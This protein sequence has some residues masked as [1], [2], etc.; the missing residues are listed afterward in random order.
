MKRIYTL[1]TIIAICCC[2]LKSFAQ[3]YSSGIGLFAGY[4]D[5]GYAT[6]L[7][8]NHYPE[9]DRYIQAG[10]YVSFNENEVR[11]IKIPY[12]NISLNIGYFKTV[13]GTTRG[14]FKLSLGLGG[15]AGYEIINNGKETLSNGALILDDSKFIYG[16]FGSVESDLYL[17]DDLSI[18]L[19]FNQF[20]HQ[21]S[22]LG[23]FTIFAGAGVR[24]ILF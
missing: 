14:Q 18:I 23:K 13:L 6:M 19:K 12:N 16:A 5:N 8:Y 4:S 11:G 24:Y 2:C 7:N 10:I 3:N 9:L 22:D 17:N 20:Y 15:V 1:P 21:N